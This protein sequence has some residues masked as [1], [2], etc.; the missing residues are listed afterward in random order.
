VFPVTIIMARFLVG[1]WQLSRARLDVHT[2]AAAAA[3][4]ASLAP[5]PTLATT[6]AT[7]TAQAALADAGRACADLDVQVDTDAFGPGG[8]VE[9]RLTC[10]VTT[11]DLIGLNAPGSAPTSASARAPIERFVE[12]EV[13]P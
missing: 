11:G 6:A 8:H 9:V 13:T 12:L 4:A 2:A 10:Q 3:R 7:D 1:T 5:S